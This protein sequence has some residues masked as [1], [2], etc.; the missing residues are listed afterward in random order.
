MSAAQRQATL[1]DL[2][3]RQPSTSGATR[4]AYDDLIRKLEAIR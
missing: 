3:A 4:R 2:K 1:A